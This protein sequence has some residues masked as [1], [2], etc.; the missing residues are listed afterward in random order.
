[1]AE[2]LDVYDANGKLIGT[3]D[4]NVVHTFGLWHKTVHCWIV[5]D[6]VRIVFQRYSHSETNRRK[7]YTTASGH[8][9]TGETINEAF[10][11]EL[12]EEVGITV[13]VSD[14]IR[15]PFYSP[16]VFNKVLN[17]GKLYVDRA[18]PET[19]FAKYSG[20]LE[21]FQFNDG[22]VSSVVAI[23]MDDY[24]ALANGEVKEIIADEYDGK[25]TQR[26]TIF[27]SDF[28]LVGRDTLYSKF[29]TIISAI[30]FLL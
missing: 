7:L 4:R 27:A 8:V 22:E 30:K 10:S 21:S 12:M 5:I 25:T 18:F 2:M 15:L 26:K 13:S 3:A 28:E 23:N 20:T 16:F 1:M 29:G 6:D 14:A 24:L 9:S 11:K 19:Y 17:D